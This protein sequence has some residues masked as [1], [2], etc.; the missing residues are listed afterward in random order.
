MVSKSAE[1]AGYPKRFFSV[2][3]FRSRVVCQML[4][5]TLNGDVSRLKPCF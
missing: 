3:S 2:H 1:W 5:N 4:L